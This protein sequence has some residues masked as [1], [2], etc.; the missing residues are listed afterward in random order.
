V[1]RGVEADR[2]L[3]QLV[4]GTPGDKLQ[5]RILALALLL[6]PK[7]AVGLSKIRVGGSNDGGYICVDDFTD[8][9]CAFSFGIDHEVSWDLSVA[10]RGL[11]VHQYDS[12][13]EGPP[14]AHENFRFERK[15]IAASTEGDNISIGALLAQHAT[16][17]PAKILLKIDIDGSEWEVFSSTTALQLQQFSQ[18]ICEFHGFN[19]VGNDELFQ[20][21]L[22]SLQNLSALF[23][24]VHVHANNFCPIAQIGGIPFPEVLEVTFLNRGRYKF[25]QSQEVFP[26]PL[27]RPN[28][29][30]HPD[31]FLGRFDWSEWTKNV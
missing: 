10:E 20:R 3:A 21:M 14:I 4:V 18:I 12:S 15:R 24:V 19:L 2:N 22:A 17:E 9:T 7:K 28:D 27:D 25:R 16:G 29:P 30:D 5:Q 13:V 26:T 8:L 1:L 11:I 23:T 6:V 31:F